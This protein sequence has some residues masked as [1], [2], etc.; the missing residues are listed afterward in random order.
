[1][2]LST[3]SIIS[4]R[5][6]ECAPRVTDR[7]KFA[8]TFYG[9]LPVVHCIRYERVN[10]RIS[11]MFHETWRYSRIVKTNALYVYI[12]HTSALL[13]SIWISRDTIATKINY[14][15]STGSALEPV[16]YASTNPIKCFTFHRTIDSFLC[17][18]IMIN[19]DWKIEDLKLRDFAGFR[20]SKVKYFQLTTIW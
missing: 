20:K 18:N 14:Q 9:T 2:Q 17:N 11:Q 10:P 12:V 15:N 6:A 4:L 3:T 7:G 1:M 5:S 8:A 16:T 13:P 19:I